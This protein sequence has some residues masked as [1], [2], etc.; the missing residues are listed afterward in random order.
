MGSTSRGLRLSPKPSSQAAERRMRAQRQR[1]T[2]IETHLRS[3]L[4]RLGLRFRVDVRPIEDT[5]CRPDIVFQAVKVAVFVDGCFW[6]RCPE[7]GTLP[8]ANAQWWR[9][10]LSSNVE[11]DQRVDKLLQSRGWEVIRVWE[12]EELLPAAIRVAEIVQHRCK[13]LGGL[14]RV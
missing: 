14:G 6:H 13:R 3:E 7:H 11:R 9:S 2:R 10:K 8:K 1:D 5:Y 4:H 12:H